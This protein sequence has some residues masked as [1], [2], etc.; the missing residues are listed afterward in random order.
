MPKTKAQLQLRIERAF[1]DVP[2]PDDDLVW[3]ADDD[4]CQSYCQHFANTHWRDHAEET[5]I[6]N[7]SA[8]SFFTDAAFK[9]F[10]PGFLSAELSDTQRDGLPPWSALGH[11]RGR[12]HN[13]RDLLSQPQRN[14][15]LSMLE[16]YIETENPESLRAYL[17]ADPETV[18]AALQGQT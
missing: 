13:S 9:F 17:Q 10:L 2:Y 12:L 16:W 15:M 14:A 4:E 5:Y 7:W 18:R 6:L 1:A 8:L 11:V 3:D